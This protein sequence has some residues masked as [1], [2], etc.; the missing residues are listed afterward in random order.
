MRYI[1]HQGDRW[2]LLA[3]RFYGDPYLYEP[4]MLE[5]PDLMRYTVL[6]EGIVIEIP[7]I[8]DTP[9]VIKP[10]WQVD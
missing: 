7:E 1:T 5:N 4:I 9:E 8:L 3:W 10:P 6:P 2:D